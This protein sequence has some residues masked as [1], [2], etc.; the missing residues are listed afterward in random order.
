MEAGASTDGFPPT[1]NKHLHHG[2]L[3][4]LTI[5][6]PPTSPSQRRNYARAAGW[7][8]SRKATVYITFFPG[9]TR[10]HPPVI[11]ARDVSSGH[12]AKRSGSAA[13]FAG[14]SSRSHPVYRSPSCSKSGR[15]TGEIGADWSAYRVRC[16]VP[17]LV[18][19][20]LAIAMSDAPHPPCEKSE[21]GESGVF[22]GMICLWGVFPPAG[23][24]SV[25]FSSL[26]TGSFHQSPS[27]APR[28]SAPGRLRHRGVPRSHIEDHRP[29][30]EPWPPRRDLTFVD[31]RRQNCHPQPL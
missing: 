8:P 13:P 12:K 16:L 10:C 15:G 25:A 27:P 31:K 23:H 20:F 7:K 24:S 18:P 6:D 1:Q 17:T 29:V 19:W 3:N 14:G 2:P 30:L 5:P 9:D 28:T 4:L 26:L 22:L 21:R 11:D